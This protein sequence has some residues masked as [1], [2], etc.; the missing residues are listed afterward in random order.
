MLSYSG[1]LATEK[2]KEVKP[3]DNLVM[4]VFSRKSF[5]LRQEVTGLIPTGL[6]NDN[7]LN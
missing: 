4:V 2:M 3:G 5:S 6:A 7:R 1:G